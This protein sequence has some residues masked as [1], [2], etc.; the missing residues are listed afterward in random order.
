MKRQFTEW[1]KIFADHVSDKGL[2]ARIFNEFLQSNIKKIENPIT[3]GQKKWTN[4]FQKLAI[5]RKKMS[6]TSVVIK[7][8]QFETL[9]IEQEDEWGLCVGGA[10]WIKR[11]Q[12][13]QTSSYKK[14]HGM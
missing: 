1:G 4:T 14:C 11:G 13:V 7:E 3:N 9:W 6:S 8:V 12:N 2:V 10:K 5:D